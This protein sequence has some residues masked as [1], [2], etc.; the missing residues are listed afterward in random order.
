METDPDD[1]VMALHLPEKRIPSQGPD[2]PPVRAGRI[3]EGST[4]NDLTRSRNDRIDCIGVQHAQI[5]NSFLN[6]PIHQPG[7][8][9]KANRPQ[10]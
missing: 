7:G 5:E 3:T 8:R 4:E 10:S 2:L 1:L 6:I 9:N